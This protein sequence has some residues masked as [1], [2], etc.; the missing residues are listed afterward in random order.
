MEEENLNELP[1]STTETQYDPDVLFT[2]MIARQDI[3]INRL[4]FITLILITVLG[5]QLIKLFRRS[6]AK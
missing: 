2:E 1:Q 6:Q 5:I 3:V 4:E